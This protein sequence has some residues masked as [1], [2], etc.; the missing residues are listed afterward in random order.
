VRKNTT[1]EEIALIIVEFSWS[2]VE[3][4]STT[5][6]SLKMTYSSFSFSGA[7]PSGL[8]VSAPTDG[9]GRAAEPPLL[10]RFQMAVGFFQ[11]WSLSSTSIYTDIVKIGGGIRV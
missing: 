7:S 2:S 11:F 8:V 4:V 1:S 3:A 9:E 10:F 5:D 6:F